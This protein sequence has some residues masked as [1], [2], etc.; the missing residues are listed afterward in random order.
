MSHYPLLRAAVLK[1]R[2]VGS[3]DHTSDLSYNGQPCP[4]HQWTT[5]STT[6]QGN[7]AYR[8]TA[9]PGSRCLTIHTGWLGNQ[10]LGL[11]S[12]LILLK[13]LLVVIKTAMHRYEP[14]NTYPCGFTGNLPCPWTAAFDHLL[15]AVDNF[16]C[17]IPRASS[18]HC[19]EIYHPYNGTALTRRV[20]SRAYA[21][22]KYTSMLSP[23]RS[24]VHSTMFKILF[25]FSLILSFLLFSFYFSHKHD[26]C[27]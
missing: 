1:L 17:V 23:V 9:C 10:S 25:L 2:P 21:G 11:I 14:Y 19:S 24:Q 13:S 12:I 22:M 8:P 15:S 7:P 20:T 18:F 4:L 16:I 27:Q 3:S 5:P 6:P 26:E